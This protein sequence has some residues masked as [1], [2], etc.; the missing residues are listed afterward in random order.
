ML[1]S[2]SLL[3]YYDVIPLGITSNTRARAYA[4]TRGVAI[5]KSLINIADKGQVCAIATYR[6]RML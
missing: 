5:A 4:R 2:I 6:Y 1:F 3:C